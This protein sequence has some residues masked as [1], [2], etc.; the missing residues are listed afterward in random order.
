LDLGKVVAGDNQ[1][2]ICEL[3]LELRQGDAA[4]LLELAAE[5]AADLPQ[6]PSDISKAQRGY[7][8]FDPNSHEVDPP[9]QK[10]LA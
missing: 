8:L 1:E 2:E 5:L 7:R 6:M 10:L 4:A 3:D 9:A